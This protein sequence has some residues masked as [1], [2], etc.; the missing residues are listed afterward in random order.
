M[1]QGALHHVYL[2]MVSTLAHLAHYGQ[3]P[4]VLLIEIITDS[5]ST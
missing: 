1:L 5:H 4:N 2:I 3:I